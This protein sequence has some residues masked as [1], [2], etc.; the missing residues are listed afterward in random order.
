[1]ATATTGIGWYLT[2]SVCV[3]SETPN[4]DW[5]IDW[6][7][8]FSG[9][10]DGTCLLDTRC[11]HSMLL[12]RLVP[13]TPLE[14][15]NIR[16]YAANGTPIPV[17]GMVTL[18]FEVAGVPVHCRFLVSDAVHEPMLGIDWLE[19]NDCQWDF[20]QGTIVDT[21]KKVVLIGRPH[22][23]HRSRKMCWFL[24]GPRWPSLSGSLGLLMRGLPIRQ[25]GCWT[26]SSCPKVS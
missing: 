9:G 11:D 1:M 4:K 6:L 12:H 21:G 22:R 8:D 15:T 14:P 19:E 2:H 17:M 3:R 5:L 26:P 7:I 20:V 25:T 24:L 16:T 13:N 23:V 18:R 10:R